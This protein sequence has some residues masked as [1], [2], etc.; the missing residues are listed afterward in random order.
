MR[1]PTHKAA[2][3]A[4][5]AAIALAGL[6]SCSIKED[7]TPCPCY[8]DV[9]FEDREHIKDPVTLIGW[10]D[11]RKFDVRVNTADYPDTYTQKVEKSMIAFGAA[12]GMASCIQ[13]GHFITVPLG[14]E[15]DSLYAFRE[16]VDCTGEMAYT[17]VRFHKQFATVFL[18]IG[19]QAS[20][21]KDYSFAVRG[22]GCGFDM[23]TYGAVQGDFRCIPATSGNMV[24]FRLPRQAD[25]SLAVTVTYRDGESL[26]FPLGRYIERIGYNWSAED[27]QD[28][29]I[30]LDI[31]N[32]RISVGVADWENA[33]DFD[34]KYVEL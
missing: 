4:A 10:T 26:E 23:L 15:C 13:D 5:G 1:N 24:Q 9:A 25:G 16:T 17:T 27:L 2:R 8:L 18:N 31:I 3:L 34:L 33:E 28:I 30:T 19:R 12:E 32:G 20:Q 7:R 14:S 22:N 6:V 21:M 11:E 29:F